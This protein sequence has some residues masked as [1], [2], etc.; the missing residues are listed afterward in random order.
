MAIAPAYISRGF[1]DGVRRGL[2]QFAALACSH[3]GLVPCVDSAAKSGSNAEALHQIL[4]LHGQAQEP[5]QLG[6]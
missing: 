5:L 1:C 6:K 3:G 2:V 4:E